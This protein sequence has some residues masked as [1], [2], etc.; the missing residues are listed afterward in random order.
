[1]GLGF[2]IEDEDLQKPKKESK[3]V[4]KVEGVVSKESNECPTCGYDKIRDGKCPKCISVDMMLSAERSIVRA[5]QLGI[6]SRYLEELVLKAR[7]AFKQERYDD[8]QNEIKEI[9]SFVSSLCNIASQLS[10]FRNVIR[11]L[12]RNSIN[13]SEFDSLLILINSFLDSG[14]LEKAREYLVKIEVGL[15]NYDVEI[16]KRKRSGSWVEG[17]DVE[18]TEL[19]TAKPICPYCENEVEADWRLCPFCNN[20]LE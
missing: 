12:E 17:K 19:T 3:V 6:K 16:E 5:K 13:V 10:L 18:S 4:S 11:S 20:E 1:R 15:K 14:N 8:A 9:N 7:S 2:V